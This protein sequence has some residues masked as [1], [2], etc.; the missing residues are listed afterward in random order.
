MRA[1]RS[2]ATGRATWCQRGVFQGE[3]LVAVQPAA[4]AGV[5]VFGVER[6]DRSVASVRAALDGDTVRVTADGPVT[7][8][9]DDGPGGIDGALARWADGFATEAGVAGIR[10]APTIWC[11]WYHYF[12][13]VTEADMDENLASMDRLDLPVESVQLDDGYQAEIGD[14]LTLSGRFVSLGGLVR[15]IR[16]VGRR[17]GIWVAPFLVG[18]RSEIARVH[19]DWLVRDEATRAPVDA[20]HNWDQ[21][22]YAL[23]TTHPDARTWLTEVFESLLGL[24][25]DYFKI[26]FLYAGAMPGRRHDR[27]L[28]EIQ[29][30]RGGLELIRR[31]IGDAYLLGCGAPILPSV[32]LV[33]A[34][35]ISPDTAPE[36]EPEDGDLSSPAGRSAVVTGVGR[37]FQQGRFWINDPD[38]IIARPAIEHREELARHVAAY[39]GL[40][41][42]SDRLAD[43]DTWGLA[44]TRRLL[45]ESP[46]ATFIP[47]VADPPADERGTR[48]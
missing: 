31:A 8:A 1:A 48:R 45:A 23:D 44:T 32:G 18:E 36:W 35:R 10:R 41:G 19:P 34:M 38:C 7:H 13:S 37:A 40:R 30:Y 15:R 24:G 2:W 14:W 9:I 25:F 22:L 12:T 4:A 46:V 33:D 5:H 27:S 3:G 16:G 11:S 26:D 28:T 17:A 29:A 21:R 47:S 39:G 20:G 42:S 6:A 43:L